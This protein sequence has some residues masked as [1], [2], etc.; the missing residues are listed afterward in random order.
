MEQLVNKPTDHRNLDLCK[1]N[2]DVAY[3]RSGGKI[4]WQPRI[5]AWFTDRSFFHVPLPQRYRE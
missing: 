1:L 4:I 3:G 2:L 5:L